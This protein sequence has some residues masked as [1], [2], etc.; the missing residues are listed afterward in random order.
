MSLL[1]VSVIIPVY[2]TKAYLAQCID[3]VIAQS[4][5]EFEAIIVDDCSTDDSAAIIDHYVQ[6]DSRLRCIKHNVNKGL[7]S[8][9]NTGV[10]AAIGQFIIHLD[11][12]DYWLRSDMLDILYQTAEVD[13]C[14]ILKFNGLHHINE[15]CKQPIVKSENIVNG[16]FHINEQFW[17]YRSVFLYFFKKEFLEQYNFTFVPNMSLGEDAIFL[18][19]TL[20]RAS[21]ISSIPEHF[22]AY[23]FDNESL[24]RKPWTLQNFMQEEEAARLISHNIS[25]VGGAFEK[26]WAYR[27]S[28]YWSRKLFARA[29]KEL[30]NEEVFTLLHFVSQSVVQCHVE[31]IIKS[32]RCSEFGKKVIHYLARSEFEAL[33]AFLQYENA[34]SSPRNKFTFLKKIENNL[35]PKLLFAFGYIYWKLVRL[36]YLVTHK[37]SV[38]GKLKK[39]TLKDV[40]FQNEEGLTDFHFTLTAATKPEGVSAM[41]RVKNEENFIINCIKSIV[42]IFDEIV[43][44]DNNSSDQTIAL[45]SSYIEEEKLSHKVKIYHYPFEIAKCGKEHSAT[46]ENSV[47][48]LSYYYN[49]CI[50]KCTLHSVVKWDADMR[51]SS[52]P[53]ARQYFIKYLRTFSNTRSWLVGSIPI[54]TVYIDNS[55]KLQLSSTEIHEENRIFINNAAFYFRKDKNW[56]VLDFT[57]AEKNKRM[58]RCVTYE[59]KDVSHDE[60]S[61]WSSLTF[62]NDRKVNE[63]RNYMLI[64][65]DMHLTGNSGFHEVTHL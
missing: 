54:Q 22:Y 40:H 43:V 13:G 20:T 6:K 63:F 65:K 3:S 64:K 5:T 61:H 10:E 62:V 36:V 29:V 58:T 39:M 26:Y 37:F 51:L 16:N 4:L 42:D 34:I 38:R 45:L 56:E 48:S 11:S 12:D 24:M 2:N 46:K 60:F 52:V 55:G 30:T 18:S 9:R 50:S 44:V 7:P 57:L 49:W 35:K 32:E 1:K 27:F 33:F 53:E 25:E 17:E 23:R 47:S 59:L 21:K 41:L 31:K 15:K 14:D 8:A 19:Q 28:H